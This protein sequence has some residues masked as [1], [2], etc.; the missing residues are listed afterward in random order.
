MA[1]FLQ[2]YP[3]Q[4][5]A[6][7]EGFD[8]IVCSGEV[9]GLMSD[10]DRLETGRERVLHIKNPT[11]DWKN[12][13]EVAPQNSQL[14]VL[15]CSMSTIFFSSAGLIPEACCMVKPLKF[16]IRTKPLIWVSSFSS[17]FSRITQ[18]ALKICD[19]RKR[20]QRCVFSRKQVLQPT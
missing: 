2:S 15:T 8:H 4:Q 20:T 14:C 11:K 6:L 3:L 17:N 5:L 7:H 19:T 16:S 12:S 18:Y 10:V 9:P 13:S 1:T